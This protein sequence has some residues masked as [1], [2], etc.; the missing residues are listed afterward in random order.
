MEQVKKRPELLHCSQSHNILRDLMLRDFGFLYYN[1]YKTKTRALESIAEMNL[2]GKKHK[3]LVIMELL[4]CRTF[5][6]LFVFI[7]F[8]ILIFFQEYDL[9]GY[10]K[11]TF[12][13]VFSPDG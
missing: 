4:L 5:I 6:E 1:C 9:P 11:A 10:P 8:I 12:L 7:L 3:E 13:M 2:V